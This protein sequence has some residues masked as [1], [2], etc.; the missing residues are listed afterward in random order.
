M[1]LQVDIDYD[2]LKIGTVDAMMKWPAI[3]SGIEKFIE[4]KPLDETSSEILQTVTAD[5]CNEG[6]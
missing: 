3:L 5:G 6:M 4:T 1:L 2:L